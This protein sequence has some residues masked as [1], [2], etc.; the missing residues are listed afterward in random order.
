MP[1]F[2]ANSFTDVGRICTSCGV[3]FGV[4]FLLRCISA[5]LR[6]MCPSRSAIPIG[7]PCPWAKRCRIQFS[8]AGGEIWWLSVR[9]TI[10]GS[11]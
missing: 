2:R 7:R 11:L 5:M 10:R 9:A 4:T 8:F 3:S 1:C 6:A